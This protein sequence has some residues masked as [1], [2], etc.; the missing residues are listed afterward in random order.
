MDSSFKSFAALFLLLAAAY[1]APTG[2][3]PKDA[4]GDVR[5]SSLQLNSVARNVSEEARNGSKDI[6]DFSTP[7]LWIE[8]QDMCGPENLKQEP[9]TC[10]EKMLNALGSYISEVERVAGFPSCARF[11]R[12]VKPFMQKLHKDM[13][14]CV[15]T[16]LGRNHLRESHSSKEET[17][18][19]AAWE[20]DLRCYYTLDR[21]FSFSILSARVF[22][23]GDPAHHTHSSA[24][25]CM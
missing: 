8:A 3:I 9:A 7:L 21:L 23:V 4:C 1:C 24:Q 20:E 6:G 25:N 13:H 10:L 18:P 17:E 22:A 15:N 5:S 2:H 19:T 11:V 14:K 12:K 16:K